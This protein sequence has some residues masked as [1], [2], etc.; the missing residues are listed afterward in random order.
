MRGNRNSQHADFPECIKSGVLE[1][2]Q[3]CLLMNGK[4]LE[5]KFGPYSVSQ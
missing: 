1:D 4:L 2:V 3:R 5:E